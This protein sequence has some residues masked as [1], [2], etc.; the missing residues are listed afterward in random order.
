MRTLF[1]LILLTLSAVAQDADREIWAAGLSISPE[2]S[3][4]VAGTAMWA[5]QIRDSNHY[6]FTVVDILATNRRPYAI[7]NNVGIGVAERAFTIHHYAVFVP[8]SLDVSDS[9]PHL[10]WSWSAGGMVVIPWRAHWHWLPNLRVVHSNV[11]N[12]SGTQLLLGLMI[13]WEQ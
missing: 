5:R 13:G 3:P 4:P 2:S 1:V 10:G 11:S 9:G 6:T 8:V 12:G 7:E